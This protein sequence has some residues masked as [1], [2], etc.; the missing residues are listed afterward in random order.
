MPV[1]TGAAAPTGVDGKLRVDPRCQQTQLHSAPWASKAAH[2][3][4]VLILAVCPEAETLILPERTCLWLL[5]HHAT[6]HVHSLFCPVWGTC[7][8]SP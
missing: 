4:V 5:H 6:R 7:C 3:S 1:T 2:S 8:P